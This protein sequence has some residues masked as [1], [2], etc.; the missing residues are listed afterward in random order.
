MQRDPKKRPSIQRILEEIKYI[1]DNKWKSFD[2]LAS[3]LS[4]DNSKK[5]VLM[6]SLENLKL[7][8]EKKAKLENQFV[9]VI[10]QA[11]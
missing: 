7:K 8:K 5:S 6:E 3:N 11:T 1:L 4:T 9:N 2:Q 10:H